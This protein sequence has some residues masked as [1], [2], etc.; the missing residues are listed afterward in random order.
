M[1]GK[2]LGYDSVAA[3]LV[4]PEKPDARMVVVPDANLK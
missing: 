1:N 2:D 4:E 3:F